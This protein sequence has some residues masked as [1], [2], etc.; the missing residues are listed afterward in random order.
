MD[1]KEISEMLFWALEEVEDIESGIK[2]VKHYESF[3]EV[4][5]DL[6]ENDND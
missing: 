5:N 4:L 2:E 1:N 3:E 6:I